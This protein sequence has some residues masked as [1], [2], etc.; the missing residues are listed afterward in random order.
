[1]REVAGHAHKLDWKLLC[2]L[3]PWRHV[4]PAFYGQSIP[5]TP[6]DIE[7]QLHLVAEMPVDELSSALTKTW[8]SCGLP[9][10]AQQ[11]LSDPT[12][13]SRR[14]ADALWDFWCAALEPHWRRLSAVH[15]DD[16]VFRQRI[17]AGEGLAPAMVSVDWRIEMDA[18]SLLIHKSDRLTM[19]T[20]GKGVVFIPSVFVG[21]SL[22]VGATG[23]AQ[24]LIIYAARRAEAAWDEDLSEQA[25]HV[26][27]LIGPTRT[28]ILCALRLPQSTTALSALLSLS[29]PA[30]SQHLS[31]LFNSG[32][33]RSSRSGRVVLYQQTELGSRLVGRSMN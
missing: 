12:S 15:D 17:V 3:A 8:Q 32:L 31:V 7:K 6:I 25:A 13:A 24:P 26:S 30:V 21:R 5:A 28:R 2:A 16:L 18:R 27:E 9:T 33:V 10:V 11:L 14:V 4:M 23:L 29:K 1:M 19:D 20:G 22:A